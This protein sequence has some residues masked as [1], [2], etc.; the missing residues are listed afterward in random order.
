MIRIL[1][2]ILS[3]ILA[4]AIPCIEVNAAEG[5]DARG[6]G[7]S[8]SRLDRIASLVAAYVD[9]GQLPGAVYAVE[10]GGRGAGT[11]AVGA[12]REDT[13][14]R[15]YSMTKPIT[16]VAVL[17]LYE[18]GRFLL[19]DPLARYLPEFADM[20]VLEKSSDGGEQLR[21]ARGPITIEQL[22]T[23]TSGLSYDD[24]APGVPGL[25]ARSDIWQADSLAEFTL[26]LSRLPLAFDPGDRWHYS[27]AND[28]LGRLVEVI[29]GEPFDRYLQ[30][31]VLQPLG[32]EDT[33]FTVPDGS[34]DRLPPLYRREGDGMALAETPEESPY[35]NAATVPWGGHGLVSTA[36]D[37]LR[38]CRMLLNGGALDGRRILAPKTVDLMLMNHLQARHGQPPLNESWIS[39][40][41]NRSGN[42]DLGFGFGYGGYVITDVAA[43]DVP[44]SE[45]TYAWGGN[46]SSYFFIDPAEDLAAVFLTQLTP[47]SAYPLR[48]Q[49][50]GLVYQAL[51]EET[52][53]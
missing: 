22:L 14:F 3:F 50:R 5:A 18:E 1:I 44:G 9:Q 28:V 48:A 29:A 36:A 39:R 26:R 49:F 45:G 10:R 20:K 34:L 31:R 21:P 16:V 17:V 6:T 12:Y 46:S 51:T 32:M 19:T 30:R 15:I 41:E 8:P 35:R 23:H 37:Y 11:A 24:D 33:G 43:N 40:T 42:L 47:S 13:L 27:V 2:S 4:C 52:T 38:F 25:Y 53:P 7:F